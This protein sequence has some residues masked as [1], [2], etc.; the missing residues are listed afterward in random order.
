MSVSSAQVADSLIDKT[1]W[2]PSFVRFSYDVAALGVSAFSKE[3][4][5]QEG[6]IE[7][8]FN[9][10]F[11]VAE[12]GYEERNLPVGYSSD[13]L[14][15]RVGPDVNLLKY[16]KSRNVIT[17]G[18]RYAGST[19]SHRVQTEVNDV[20]GERSL[21]FEEK[22]ITGQWFEAGFGLK[23]KI[24]KQL[25]MGYDVRLKFANSIKG[26]EDILPFAVPGFG[27]FFNDGREKVGLAV[28]FHYLIYWT[29]PFRDKPVPIKKPKKIKRFN[30]PLE[31]DENA[32]GIR[33]N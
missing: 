17:F 3:R 21:S 25:F 30:S 32:A 9:H 5:V 23:I 1:P 20:F 2:A 28:G 18:L 22:N 15:Y 27:R 19:F 33:R 11:L 8:D 24:W 16:D 13:G 26:N 10:L 29:I 4:F 14:Y 7:T 31:S 12:F 6:R